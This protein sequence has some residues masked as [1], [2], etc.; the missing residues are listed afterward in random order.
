VTIF[1]FG[2]MCPQN[3][4]LHLNHIHV[5]PERAAKWI[6]LRSYAKCMRFKSP[7]CFINRGSRFSMLLEFKLCAIAPQCALH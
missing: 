3:L 2:T 6:V 4:A 5:V 1:L 7:I